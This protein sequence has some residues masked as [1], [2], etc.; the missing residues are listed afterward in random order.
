M[1][2]G[3]HR[4]GVRRRWERGGA[5]AAGARP[6]ERCAER[7]LC[8]TAVPRPSHALTLLCVAV[9]AFFGLPAG[10]VQTSLNLTNPL[11]YAEQVGEA[12]WRRHTGR[13][14][15]P[16]ATADAVASAAAR[17]LPGRGLQ[18]WLRDACLGSHSPPAAACRSL[19]CLQVSVGA[20]YGSQSSSE[21]HLALTKP[22]PWGKPL[23]ADVR[24]HQLGHNYQ[25][26]SSYAELL[27][28]GQVTLSRWD[29][30]AST[31]PL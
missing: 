2:V 31:G 1:G 28:G 9:L 20:E 12:R 25:R 21:F 29:D 15:S 5:G 7:T 6:G 18:P 26:W 11:G 22:K 14:A 17:L 19:S 23:L 3:K 13:G 8:L 30:S 10:S 24:L 4:W 16:P 27:R